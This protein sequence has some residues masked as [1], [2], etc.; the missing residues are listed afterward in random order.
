MPKPHAPAR[1]KRR[2]EGIMRLWRAGQIRARRTCRDRYLT[3]R[4]T[5]QWRLLS[6]DNGQHW[7][8]LSHADYDKQI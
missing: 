1:I 7:E 3:L 8:L 2:A 4:V 5:P 6:R